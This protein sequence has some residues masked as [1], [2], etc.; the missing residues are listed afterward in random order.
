MI[1]RNRRFEDEST[2]AKSITIFV[3]IGIL[4][5][6]TS[7]AMTSYPQH[8]ALSYGTVIQAVKFISVNTFIIK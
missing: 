5:F 2:T 8:L 6:S 7:I 4:F 1:R 3:L